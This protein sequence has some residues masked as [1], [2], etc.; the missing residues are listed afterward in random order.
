MPMSIINCLRPEHI[1]MWRPPSQVSVPVCESM[2]TIELMVGMRVELPVATNKEPSCRCCGKDF[3]NFK[4]KQ[5]HL[6][7]AFHPSL[8][9]RVI[10]DD[11]DSGDE[12]DDE[13]PHDVPRSPM[14]Y[15]QNVS[16]MNLE[17]QAIVAAMCYKTLQRPDMRSLHELAKVFLDLTA[18]GLL[19]TA[20]THQG[21]SI[22]CGLD[23]SPSVP[24]D[25]CRS[26]EKR[27]K[28]FS[29]HGFNDDIRPITGRNFCLHDLDICVDAFKFGPKE[30]VVDAFRHLCLKCFTLNKSTLSTIM[31]T[32]DGASTSVS[33]LESLLLIPEFAGRS[34]N[35]GEDLLRL[36]GF[37]EWQGP[38]SN[39]LFSVDKE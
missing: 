33:I 8:F 21:I 12:S 3:Q 39:I 32:I 9:F 22:L 29:D 35:G 1:D 37:H 10:G 27:Y 5:R 25:E 23:G 11:K 28:R 15:I 31:E 24:W 20:S 26:I 38:C 19:A 4:S 36:H 14:L 18:Y 34:S 16:L 30:N 13:S 6:E 17:A 2:L 7:P